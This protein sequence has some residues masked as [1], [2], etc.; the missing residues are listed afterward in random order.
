MGFNSAFKGLIQ[1]FVNTRLHHHHHY[2]HLGTMELGHLMPHSG[3][4]SRSLFKW[5][6]CFHLLVGPQFLI[7]SAIYGTF[8]LYVAN[9]FFLIPVFYPNPDLCLVILQYLCFFMICPSVSCCISQT[10]HPCR[11]YSSCISSF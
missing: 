4:T 7:F 3:P 2:H 5:S 10:F 9:N 1:G 11:C 8:C 6:A